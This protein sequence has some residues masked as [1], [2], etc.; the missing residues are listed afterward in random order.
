MMA[1]QREEI[2][3]ATL[4]EVPKCDCGTDDDKHYL[5]CR[6]VNL[7]NI[8]PPH[9]NVVERVTRGPGEVVGQCSDIPIEWLT[10]PVN[11]GFIKGTLSEVTFHLHSGHIIT[12]RSKS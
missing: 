11:A 8:H 2:I 10:E 1:H 9:Q 12:Y 3:K 7:A 6:M 5:S 4:T